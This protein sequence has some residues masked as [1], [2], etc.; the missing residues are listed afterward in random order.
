MEKFRV[1]VKSTSW[2]EAEIFAESLDEAE[3]KAKDIDGGE[4]CEVSSDWEIEC[5]EP[6]K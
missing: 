3:Q 1:T 6:T 5:V 4:F 2:L